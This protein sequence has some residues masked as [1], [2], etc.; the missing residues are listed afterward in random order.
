MSDAEAMIIFVVVIVFVVQLICLFEIMRLSTAIQSIID[1]HVTQ[2]QKQNKKNNKTEEVKEIR[3][4]K[5]TD[6][7]CV[8]DW[9]IINQYMKEC[10]NPACKKRQK[11]TPRSQK[12]PL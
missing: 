4:G 6:V 10:R 2:K 1:F 8:H 12:R 11:I 7:V 9:R 5:D 3:Y